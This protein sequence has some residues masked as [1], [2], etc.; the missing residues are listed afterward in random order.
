MQIIRPLPYVAQPASTRLG[1]FTDV[2]G[3]ARSLG[4][5]AGADET[6]LPPPAALFPPLIAPPS[7]AA[8][9][10]GD[11]EALAPTTTLRN[12]AIL[13]TPPTV[14][15][16]P[17]DAAPVLGNAFALHRATPATASSTTPSGN[18]GT[19]PVIAVDAPEATT[20]PR[21]LPATPTAHTTGSS[22]STGPPRRRKFSLLSVPRMTPFRVLPENVHFD[23]SPL[24]GPSSPRTPARGPRINPVPPTPASPCPVRPPAADL[25]PA[26]RAEAVSSDVQVLIATIG[27]A[28]SPATDLVPVTRTEAAPS[29]VEASE[30]DEVEA[31]TTALSLMSLSGGAPSAAPGGL[32]TAS[33]SRM[34]IAEFGPPPAAC[35]DVALL[36]PRAKKDQQ[37]WGIGAPGEV[38]LLAG[39]EGI[40]LPPLKRSEYPGAKDYEVMA[41]AAAEDAGVMAAGTDSGEADE[42]TGAT[43]ETD[44]EEAEA[45]TGQQDVVD[46]FAL[47]PMNKEMRSIARYATRLPLDAMSA[48][49]RRPREQIPLELLKPMEGTGVTRIALKKLQVGPPPKKVAL[50]IFKP[51]S[52]TQL[53]KPKTKAAVVSL[54]PSGKENGGRTSVDP[55]TRPPSVAPSV[56]PPSAIPGRA[57]APSADATVTVRPPSAAS[58]MRPP[59][60]ATRFPVFVRAGPP[61]AAPLPRLTGADPR[62]PSPAPAPPPASLIAPRGRYSAAQKGKARAP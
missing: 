36:G 53:R 13:G 29:D 16:L 15:T 12:L 56:G 4:L 32:L 18:A 41:V 45:T 9:P 31:L 33:T 27:A 58:N 3:L 57:R 59:S 22:G 20:P 28:Q 55:I 23:G 39:W 47:A 35:L 37:R 30:Q 46:P 52:N 51:P 42:A 60:R 25:V 62:A 54:L 1:V 38:S 48:G 17:L 14:K 8:A 11:A 61:T 43:E 19:P 40:Q 6:L 7:A 24:A 44:K 26:T 10:G 2:F 5:E 50:P 49:L 34:S 21:H